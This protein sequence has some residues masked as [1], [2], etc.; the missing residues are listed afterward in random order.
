MHPTPTQEDA[1]EAIRLGMNVMITGPAGTG[2][3]FI[4]DS[5]KRKLGRS[6][7][8]QVTAMTGM[9][10]RVVRGCTL[11]SFLNITFGNGTSNED[12]WKNM[13]KNVASVERIASVQT[14]VI[15]ECTSL[16]SQR[17][18]IVI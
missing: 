15:D 16:V 9:A 18:G 2:K 7:V 1:I 3:S 13:K 5:A 6:H 17:K 11:H 4:L 14:L 12:A 8:M 10:A